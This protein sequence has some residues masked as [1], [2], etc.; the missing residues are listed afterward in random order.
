MIREEG[1]GVVKWMRKGKEGFVKATNTVKSMFV[2]L[3]KL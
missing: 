3:L 2:M 1:K